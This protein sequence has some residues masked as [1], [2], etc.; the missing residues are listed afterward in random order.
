MEEAEQNAPEQDQDQEGI[1][2]DGSAPVQQGDA[3]VEHVDLVGVLSDEFGIA[4]SVAQR[5]MRMGTVT[6]DDEPL[7]SL[8][9][10]S[11]NTFIVLREAVEGR[12]VEVVGGETNRTYRF[13]IQ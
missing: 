7:T 6:V 11:V 10:I 3:V 8:P 12:T 13:Q 4:R 2:R 1:E 5:D 9:S